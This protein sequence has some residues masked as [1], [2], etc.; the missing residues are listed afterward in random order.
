MIIRSLHRKMRDQ[1]LRRMGWK[2]EVRDIERK[3]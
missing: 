3:L 1:H 2:E